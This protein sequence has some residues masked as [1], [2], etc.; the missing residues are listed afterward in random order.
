M[1]EYGSPAEPSSCLADD[2]LLAL[3]DQTGRVFSRAVP[4]IPAGLAGACLL[5]LAVRERVAL[6]EASA[7]GPAWWQRLTSGP[8]RLVAV[9]PT[10]T[11]DPLLDDVLASIAAT[12]KP[13]ST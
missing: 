12:Y 10:P 8:R 13:R 5:D 2:L 11:G 3:D 1:W 6:R 9:D 4:S 7:A